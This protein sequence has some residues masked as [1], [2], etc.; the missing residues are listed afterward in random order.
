MI[1]LNVSVGPLCLA[2]HNGVDR[3]LDDD[4]PDFNNFN[5]T[6]VVTCEPGKWKF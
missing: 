4:F 1:P 3:R 2:R 5:K 6:L